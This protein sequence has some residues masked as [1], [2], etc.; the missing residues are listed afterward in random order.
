MLNIFQLNSKPIRHLSIIHFK[1]IKRKIYVVKYSVTCSIA[2][3]IAREDS[4][5]IRHVWIARNRNRYL[6]D[7]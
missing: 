3:G 7:L 2:V 1:R 4:E 5:V 6:N